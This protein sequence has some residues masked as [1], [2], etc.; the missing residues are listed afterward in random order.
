M[1]ADFTNDLYVD[2]FFFKICYNNADMLARAASVE[3]LVCW[4]NIGVDFVFNIVYRKYS[5]IVKSHDFGF[6]L[7]SRV[8]IKINNVYVNSIHI[9][10][11]R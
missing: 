5:N 1:I 7:C 11:K 8:L 10:S 6:R 9:R 3:Y 2:D 4:E